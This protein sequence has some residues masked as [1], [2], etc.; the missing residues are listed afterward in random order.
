MLKTYNFSSNKNLRVLM[1]S[2]RKLQEHVSYCGLYEFEDIIC[3]LDAVDLV[4]PAKSYDLSKEIYCLVKRITRSS[5]FANS[6]KPDPNSFFLEQEYELFFAN[7]ASPW[8][9]LS[10]NSIKGWRKKC[11]KAVCRLDEIWEKDIQG[12]KPL[13]ELLMDFDH[14]FLGHSRGT[15]AIADITGRPCTYLPPSVDT[16]KFCPYPLS[17]HR[18]IDVCCMGRRSP[19][20]HKALLDLAEQ[21][22]FY[23]YDTVKDFGD[24]VDLWIN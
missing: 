5:Q 6:I 16:I 19:V 14:I 21:G 23:S 22:K 3:D 24:V 18:S 13:L 4:T 2:Q 20:T 12:W 15:K 9:I 7:F 10:I 11:Q 8:E 1:L 17:P